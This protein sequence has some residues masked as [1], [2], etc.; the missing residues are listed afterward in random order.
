MVRPTNEDGIAAVDHAFELTTIPSQPHAQSAM[1]AQTQQATQTNPASRTLPTRLASA[2]MQ[3]IPHSLSGLRKQAAKLGHCDIETTSLIGNGRRF[4]QTFTTPDSKTSTDNV[5]LSHAPMPYATRQVA[6]SS[7]RTQLDMVRAVGAFVP[8]RPLAIADAATHAFARSALH[9][10]GVLDNFIRQ[11]FHT[12]AQNEAEEASEVEST[13]DVGALAQRL[14][15]LCDA[16]AGAPTVAP[17]VRFGEAVAWADALAEATGHDVGLALRVI[18]RLGQGL[19]VNAPASGEDASASSEG[20]N[21]VER[22]A[23]RT[24]QLMSGTANG[25]D[26]VKRLAGER[27]PSMEGACYAP[28]VMLRAA[29]AIVRASHCA[30]DPSAVLARAQ[31]WKASTPTAEQTHLACMVEASL[32]LWNA[33]DVSA[34]DPSEIGSVLAGRN[35][36][37]TDGPGTPLAKVKSRLLKTINTSIPRA[38]DSGWKT[39]LPRIVGRKKSAFT[40]LSKGI[41]SAHLDI[42]EKERPMLNASAAN[43]VRT[44]HTALAQSDA[45]AD[46]HIHSDARP[47]LNALVERAELAQWAGRSELDYGATL[48]DSDYLA[49]ASRVVG[50]IEGLRAPGESA[51]LGEREAMQSLRHFAVKLRASRTDA[52][53]AR[54]ALQPHL[55]KGSD[56]LDLDMLETMAGSMAHLAEATQGDF[57]NLRR[58]VRAEPIVPANLSPAAIREALDELASTIKSGGKVM[59]VDGGQVGIST[60]GLSANVGKL[61]TAAGIVVSPRLNLRARGGRQAFFEYGRRTACFYFTAGSQK[62]VNFEAGGGLQVGGDYLLLRA[63]VT[64]N[65]IAYQAD[66][67][68]RNAFSLILARR[69][70]EDGSGFDDKRLQRG[71][72]DINQFVFEHAQAHDLT[73]GDD[74]WNALARTFLVNDDFSVVWNDQTQRETHHGVSV[75]GGLTVKAGI[76]E[77][78][79]RIGPQLGYAYDYASRNQGTS[80]DTNGT[81]AVETHRSGRGGRH[82]VSA[83]V[84]VSVGD[85][86]HAIKD[87]ASIG[88]LS[89]DSPLMR[90]RV[91]D[92]QHMA[93]VSLVREEGRLV[94]RVSYAD[95]EFMHFNDYADAVRGDERWA[96]MFGM[97]LNAPRMPDNPDERHAMLERG[98]ARIDAHLLEVKANYRQNQV[99]F[100]RFRLREH[101]AK[102]LDTYADRI[103]MLTA[104]R[105]PSDEIAHWEADYAALLER[106]DSWLPVEFKVYERVSRQSSPGLNLGVRATLEQSATGERELISMIHKPAQLDAIDRIWQDPPQADDR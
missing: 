100:H 22:A 78:S 106:P 14:V 64:V 40:A 51:S 73:N 66:R 15:G 97:D 79:L 105:A 58:I 77:T 88:L 6:S 26:A 101:A 61:L 47:T 38:S 2:T 91:R 53:L 21:D 65:V 104:R 44:L 32:K 34:L 30:A 59:L 36:F 50:L 20:A 70:K 80:E 74:A 19:D 81:T 16:A 92:R 35:G 94:H 41:Y 12:G 11:N 62:R 76:G 24:A 1:Q 28:R 5:R 69:M 17:E 60:S 93:K 67:L 25:Y 46:R 56:V 23:W 57:K 48:D 8:S 45:E 27:W 39:A 9:D 52:A 55:A 3:S 42:V 90:V 31:A 83:G 43:I 18:E 68:D 96:L 33:N 82:I 7:T 98:R 99:M 54:A 95:T 85:S 37:M 84:T 86:P 49:I 13:D 4:G 63:G 102:A 89:A 75:T 10:R 87:S 72:V 103:A 71:M 29:D